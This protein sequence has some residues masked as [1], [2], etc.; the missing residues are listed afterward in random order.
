MVARQD[1][2]PAGIKRQRIVDSV[3]SAEVSDRRFGRDRSREMKIRRRTRIT[4]V[5]IK[6][7]GQVFYA[8]NVRWINGPFSNPKI[9]RFGQETAGIVLALL[10][11]FCVEIAKSFRAI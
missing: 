11:N 7:R 1:A 10:P 8:L 4:Q 2:E 5:G 6:T 9:G 3:F